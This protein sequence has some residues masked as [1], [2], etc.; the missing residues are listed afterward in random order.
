MEII[1]NI[2]FSLEREKAGGKAP[3]PGFGNHQGVFGG[4]GSDA[5]G[6]LEQQVNLRR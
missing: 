2:A 4:Y 3:G 1:E 5:S 6:W